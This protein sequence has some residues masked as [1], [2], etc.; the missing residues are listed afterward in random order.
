MPTE[1][2]IEPGFV[3]ELL[4]RPAQEQQTALLRNAGLLNP[5][6][7]DLLLDVADRALGDDP[8]RTRQI[9]ELCVDVADSALAPAA[10][11]RAHY[12]LA[13]VHEI[14]GDF[15]SEGR[16]IRAAHDE[17]AALGMELE[18]L[19]TNVGLMVVFLEQGDYQR[20][21][22]TGRLVLEALEGGGN[23]KERPTQAQ[24][25]LLAAPVHLNRG[26]CYEYMG[27][28]G[29]ALDAYAEAENHYR[30]LG[31]AE[32]IGEILSNRGVILLSLGRGG[33]ALEAHET[34][35]LT[36]KKAGLDLSHAK[37]LANMGEAYLSLG[38][39]R[40]G[41]GAFERARSLLAP[42][43][44]PADKSLLFRDLANAYL[45]LNLYTEAVATYQGANGML[46]N[47]GMVH[48]QA[49]VLWGMGSALTALSRFEE[50]REALEGAADLFAAA[51]N[52]P[53]LSGVML[54]RAS[55]SE[56]LGDR[57]GALAIARRALEIASEGDWPVHLVYAHLRVAELSPD[58]VAAE[59]HLF[60]AQR[61]I[62][63][64]GLP[65]LRYRLNE[66][67]GRLRLMQGRTGEAR[68]LLEA[69][70]EQIERLRGT[71]VQES[72]RTSFLRDKVVAYEDLLRLYLA[73][74]ED[75][76]R[77]LSIAERAK[78]R[79]LVD[80]LIGVAEKGP[81]AADGEPEG[82][83]RELQADLNA[84]YSRILDDDV[85]EGRVALLRELRDRAG[86]LEAEIGRFR[87]QAAAS[88]DPFVAQ[89]ASRWEHLAG[90][91]APDA[92]L[93]AYHIV[94]EEVLA[95]VVSGDDV[96]AVRRL[97][98]VASV[99]R[100]LERLS[101]QW[102][103]FRAGREFAGRHTV[104]LERSARQVLASLHDELVAPLEPRLAGNVRGVEEVPKLVVVPHG[105]L[106]R[107]PFHALFD[108]RRYL[109]E[110]FEVSYAP[111][112][113][114]YG[115]CQEQPVR[116]SGRALAFGVEDSSIPAAAGEALAVAENVPGA[117]ARVG[118]AATLA[119]LRGE[120]PG[121][122]V[123]HLACHG[124]FRDDNPMFSSLKLHDGWL[125]A[126]DAMGLDLPGALVTL[127]ACESG[128]GEVIGG[129]EVLGLTRAF[130]GAGAATLVV[131]LWLAQDE[132]TAA[133]MEDWYGRM[134]GGMGRAAALRAAQLELKERH[135]H[136]YYWAPFLLI[137]KR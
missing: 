57:E 137:G 78:S 62:E 82:R 110:R 94:G 134:G 135:P 55:L 92:T 104:L 106:H 56:A 128:R 79:A 40:N 37:A 15:E 120:A 65:Q 116:G 54:E 98:T 42:L 51:D 31:M 84:T 30:A 133:L 12:L 6:G 119:A 96:R 35:T 8:G 36:F 22:D 58:T 97:C 136:P 122:D 123:L 77:A 100:L 95:F 93:V 20:S 1:D 10:I 67:L 124:L 66:R 46:R 87:L 61:L 48:D 132:T 28:F 5:E 50:A 29:E 109:L 127:S 75:A 111:S 108:G 81:T 105:P 89:E 115:L 68:S 27:R 34:A 70:A 131:S 18:A 86:A 24:Y 76:W 103:R 129:D 107:V 74:D 60:E 130:L 39:Y 69:A 41:L 25:D 16:L 126:S 102:D 91:H 99:R 45:A 101:A 118:E 53:L 114:V 11:P 9:V 47:A 23:L 33:E 19:R 4:A 13:Q 112:V 63:G 17:Y 49:R 72:L 80:L 71:V 2:G 90:R 43:D 121:C 3:G 85:G 44:A 113:S 88:A 7:L 38:D 125:S 32:R 64:V 21:L 14:N 59:D 117:T 52:A 83:L 73:D 26:G